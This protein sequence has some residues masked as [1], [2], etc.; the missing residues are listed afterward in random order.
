[1]DGPLAGTVRLSFDSIGKIFR[2][3]YDTGDG[4]VQ[5]GSFGV[6][7]AG[8]G[9]DGNGDWTMADTDQFCIS[10]QN[11]MNAAFDTLRGLVGEFGSQL[12]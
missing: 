2:T 6:S 1:M 7:D 8:G 12:W 11:L 10:V 3:F 5:F 4:W 9:V